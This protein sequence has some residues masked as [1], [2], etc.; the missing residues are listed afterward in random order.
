MPRV[1][2]AG[3]VIRKGFGVSW[4]DKMF[5]GWTKTQGAWVASAYEGIAMASREMGFEFDLALPQAE[6]KLE[7]AKPSLF[8]KVIQERLNKCA[9]A[10]IVFTGG[11]VSAA[12]EAA[13]ASMMQKRQLILADDLRQLPRL[14]S[15]LP[16]VRIVHGTDRMQIL[17]EVQSF[18]RD[19]KDLLY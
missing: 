2:V 7:E 3:P 1:Y 8:C 15:G 12:V 16:G 6:E 17:H 13:M 14:L 10:V 11:D 4:R 18:F 9:L 5:P 19:N